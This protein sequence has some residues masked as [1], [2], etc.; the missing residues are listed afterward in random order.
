VQLT[1]LKQFIL[2]YLQD[3]KAVSAVEYGL[4]VAGVAI[5]IIASAFIVGDSLEAMFNVLS[6]F[7]DSRIE[8]S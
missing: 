2:Y 4:I 3:T 8:S 7:M 6:G 5:A 1:D